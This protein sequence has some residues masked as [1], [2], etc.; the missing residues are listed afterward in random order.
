M[1]KQTHR[2]ESNVS[3]AVFLIARIIVGV[4]ALVLLTLGCG[5]FY[6]TIIGETGW[7]GVPLGLFMFGGGLWFGW[8]AVRPHRQNV[9]D[10]STDIV[11][12]I[13]AEL[14]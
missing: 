1:P 10:M 2:S 5:F 11:A 9:R 6:G 8:S 4:I 7:W 13:L 12:R 14:F 3:R